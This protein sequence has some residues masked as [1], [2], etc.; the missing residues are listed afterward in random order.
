[1]TLDEIYEAIKNE[2]CIKSYKINKEKTDNLSIY[3]SSNDDINEL[4]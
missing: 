3:I 1:M 4:Q 2:T